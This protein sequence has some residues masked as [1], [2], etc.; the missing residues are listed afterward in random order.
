MPEQNSR[1]YVGLDIAKRQLDY[2][3]SD[4]GAATVSYSA[5]GLAELIGRLRGR[6]HP[7]VVCEAT[8]GYERT[9]VAALGAAGIEV[10]LVQPGRV[11]AF[12]HARGLLAKTDP[13]DA[14]LLRQFGQT[15]HPRAYTPVTRAAS[16]LRAVLEYRGLLVAQLA[17]LRSRQDVADG[18][19]RPLLREHQARLQA[20]LAPIEA[21]LQAQL[22]TIP[23]LA[24]KAQRL[25][26]VTGVGVILAASL[27]AYVPELG[28]ISDKALSALVGVAPHPRDSA[29][30]ARPRQVRGGRA[31]VRR[32]L[33]MS[34]VCAARFNRT[35]KA[36]YLRLRAAGKPAMVAIVAVMRKLLCLLN[37]LI[38]DPDFVL[39]S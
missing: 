10:C 7:C 26:Q 24:P 35:L 23:E 19:L 1:D 33:Y 14:R 2:A 18:G 4:T 15:L 37:R 17:E 39:A 28:Q 3:L 20:A 9:V 16:E 38:A 34:A 12:A 21:R 13:I 22:Q 27:L 11:R 8:G 31:A 32:V 36:F 29:A 30:N 6:A 5:A 25:Q